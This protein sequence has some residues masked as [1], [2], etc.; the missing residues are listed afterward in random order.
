V[1]REIDPEKED[2]DT[3]ELKASFS[4]K[5]REEDPFERELSG[6]ALDYTHDLYNL[7]SKIG[8]ANSTTYSDGFQLSQTDRAPPIRKLLDV[9][10]K[11]I[12]AVSLVAQRAYGINPEAAE[13]VARDFLRLVESRLIP[14]TDKDTLQM[15]NEWGSGRTLYQGRRYTD[16]QAEENAKWEDYLK[17]RRIAK[18]RQKGKPEYR[19]PSSDFDTTTTATTDSAFFPDGYRATDSDNYY[20]TWKKP[21]GWDQ[22]KVSELGLYD[23]WNRTQKRARKKAVKAYYDRLTDPNV[24]Q[25]KDY[26]DE[27]AAEGWRRRNGIKA[28]HELDDNEKMVHLTVKL[29]EEM[30]K[31]IHLLRTVDLYALRDCGR[32]IFKEIQ[33][34]DEEIQVLLQ[35]RNYT[36]G[37]LVLDYAQGSDRMS[38]RINRWLVTCNVHFP[39]GE[40]KWS[41]DDSMLWSTPQPCGFYDCECGEG[42]GLVDP[43]ENMRKREIILSP[44]GGEYA[45]I[46]LT[47][48]AAFKTLEEAKAYAA[49]LSTVS[50]ESFQDVSFDSDEL[51]PWRPLKGQDNEMLGGGDD[52]DSET[53]GEDYYIDEDNEADIGET[54]R[55]G[56]RP[57]EQRPPGQRSSD[58][59]IENMEYRTPDLEDKEKDVGSISSTEKS[60]SEL[61]ALREAENARIAPK[62]EAMFRP[63]QAGDSGEDYDSVEEDKLDAILERQQYGA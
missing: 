16:I 6:H 62:P 27:M 49:N 50:S 17:K 14:L 35:H 29:R 47:S 12:H 5:G 19:S 43:M 8:I 20:H 2:L 36:R 33:D 39:L 51:G 7:F 54:M 31:K 61:E 11:R 1:E 21:P 38:S 44:F 3:D 34:L 23:P 57:E 24:I 32:R 41:M 60:E 48:A 55:M 58:N 13:S 59:D 46:N 22:L 26:L 15:L 56:V 42:F 9:E 45:P 25:E 10:M 53:V 28:F 4:G 37:K 52:T 40:K 30:E 18:R 63:M